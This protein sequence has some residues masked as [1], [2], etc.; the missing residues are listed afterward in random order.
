MQKYFS[1][2]VISVK[3]IIHSWISAS[4]NRVFTAH[5]QSHFDIVYSWNYNYANDIKI[6]QFWMKCCWNFVLKLVN[7]SHII[8]HTEAYLTKWKSSCQMRKLREILSLSMVNYVIKS[9]SARK[10]YIWNV[11]TAQNN[12]FHDLHEKFSTLMWIERWTNFMKYMC[13]CILMTW[14]IYNIH[15]LKTHFSSTWMR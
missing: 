12:H 3:C 9:I 15:V 4:V 10:I 2:D 13:K 1:H 8:W 7:A 11:C 6:P 14:S 5:Q